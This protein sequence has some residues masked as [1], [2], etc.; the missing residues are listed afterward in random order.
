MLDLERLVQFFSVIHAGNYK[1]QV[2]SSTTDTCK[3]LKTIKNERDWMK[4]LTD[5]RSGR[6]SVSGEAGWYR[7]GVTTSSSEFQVA[8]ADVPPGHRLTDLSVLLLRAS[9]S[10]LLY[11]LYIPGLLPPTLLVFIFIFVTWTVAQTG[12]CSLYSLTFP[13]VPSLST[14]ASFNTYST[15]LMIANCQRFPLVVVRRL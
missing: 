13:V 5:F 7:A 9:Q 8:V 12:S 4:K 11:S 1:A 14:V 2:C 6:A 10:Y 3:I 15:T